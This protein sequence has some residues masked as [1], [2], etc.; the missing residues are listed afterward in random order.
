MEN[1]IMERVREGDF[2]GAR[3]A[4]LKIEDSI[5]LEPS[6][7][8][9]RALI[10]KIQRLKSVYN[11]HMPLD[12]AEILMAEPFLLARQENEITS[13]DN[14]RYVRNMH[15]E[16]VIIE[17]CCE[18]LIEQCSGCVFDYFCSETSVLLVDVKSSRISCSAHQ[19]RLNNCEDV[20]LVVHT[21][22]GVYL[23]RCKD[24]VIGRYGDSECNKF[25]CVYDFSNPFGGGSYRIV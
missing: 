9:K 24:I 23:Q 3:K 6:L 2:E 25:A 22:T 10:D 12:S 18:A 17:D 4:I 21:Q 14:K 19:I 20:E 5:R 11:H 1:E 16:N 8:G 15:G 7:Y 13:A